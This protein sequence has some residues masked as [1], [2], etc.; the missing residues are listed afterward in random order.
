[1]KKMMSDLGVF[2]L[3]FPLSFFKS[4]PEGLLR[5]RKREKNTQVFLLYVL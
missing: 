1:M 5:E 3:F 4:S 2:L